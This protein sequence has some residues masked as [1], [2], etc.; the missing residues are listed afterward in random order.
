MPLL[1]IASL[2]LGDCHS[3][4]LQAKI[5]AA[6]SAGFSSIEL[7]DND[8]F[9]FLKSY[10]HSKG[11]DEDEDSTAIAAAQEVGSLVKQAGLKISCLQPLRDFEGWM[12]SEKKK[13]AYERARKFYILLPHLGTDLLLVPSNTSPANVLHSSPQEAV[14]DLTW[15]A[16]RLA[17][18]Q[19]PCRLA[20]EGL[21]WGTRVSTWKQT[22]D[23]IRMTNRDNVGICLDS[24][25][26]LAREWA[27]PYSISGKQE[28]ADESLRAS[29]RELSRTI[30]KEKIFIY[31]VAD[32]KLMSPPLLPPEDPS[33]PPLRPWSRSH[34][35]FPLETDLGA[36]LPV[37]EFSKVVKE[38]GYDGDWSLEVFNDSLLRVE[39]ETVSQHASRGIKGLKDLFLQLEEG[40][41]SKL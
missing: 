36:Y 35:L 31:Q 33:I 25:N 41:Q 6:S 40:G 5:Q 16:D 17:E 27:D 29:L 26:S 21:S 8:W 10:A 18:L 32:A 22:W 12:D 28:K 3:H 30:P 39:K 24:F 20:Y 34:R 11:Q 2:S 7:F 37:I 14:K 1:G 9:A 15:L 19:P 38:T 4:S 23:V 13:D